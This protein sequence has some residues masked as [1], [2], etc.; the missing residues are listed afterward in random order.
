MKL[1]RDA[2][3]RTFVPSTATDSERSDNN[4]SAPN[5][6]SVAASRSSDADKRNFRSVS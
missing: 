1:P 3:P 4:P 5:S 6:P 2:F